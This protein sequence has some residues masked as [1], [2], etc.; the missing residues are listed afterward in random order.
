MEARL[1]ARYWFFVAMLVIAGAFVLR[2]LWIIPNSAA[3][4]RHLAVL[5]ALTFLIGFLVLMERY[6][7]QWRHFGVFSAVARGT[8]WLA[9]G[10]LTIAIYH[11]PGR[12][13]GLPLILLGLWEIAEQFRKTRAQ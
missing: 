1:V 7:R 11:Q 8:I 9:G 12:W 10:G 4:P 5:V 6:G 3:L 2:D 13:W